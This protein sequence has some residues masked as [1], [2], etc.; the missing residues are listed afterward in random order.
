[1]ATR[2]TPGREVLISGWAGYTLTNCLPA[3]RRGSRAEGDLSPLK[4]LRFCRTPLPI[5]SFPRSLFLSPQLRPTY[6]SRRPLLVTLHRSFFP[7][8]LSL[9]L[10]FSC[11]PP[12]ARSVSLKR[13]PDWKTN[14]SPATSFFASPHPVSQPR[15]L[16]FFLF[17]ARSSQTCYI[18]TDNYFFV[19][20][21]LKERCT[22]S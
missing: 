19:L 11:A 1:M 21:F 7:G 5:P 13:T 14:L 4:G 10:S 3:R 2:A 18:P 15:V 12:C 6:I 20:R 22:V 16:C 8:A 17:E 9:S